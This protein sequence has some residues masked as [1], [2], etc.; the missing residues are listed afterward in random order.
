MGFGVFRTVVISIC[1]GLALQVFALQPATPVIDPL[2]FH[3]WS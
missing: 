2:H 3:R 1:V